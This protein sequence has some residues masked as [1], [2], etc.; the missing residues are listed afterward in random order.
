VIRSFF[1][2]YCLKEPIS[3]LRKLLEFFIE[4][5]SFLWLLSRFS[6]DN[7]YAIRDCI[8]SRSNW[9]IRTRAPI[10]DQSAIIMALPFLSISVNS[11]NRACETHR[12]L[13]FRVSNEWCERTLALSREWI[14]IA[15]VFKIRE[16]PTI[17]DQTTRKASWRQEKEGDRCCV[18]FTRIKFLHTLLRAGRQLVHNTRMLIDVYPRSIFVLSTIQ[19]RR[20]RDDLRPI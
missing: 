8:R 3:I 20:D 14:I 17:S 16:S 1:T 2:C 10:G 5:R 12:G 11:A 9:T 19:S 18:T 6:V 4:R 13:R 7:N 15:W